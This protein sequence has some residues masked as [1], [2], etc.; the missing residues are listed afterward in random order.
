MKKLIMVALMLMNHLASADVKENSNLVDVIGRNLRIAIE[1]VK[2]P[3]QSP[4]GHTV[5][6]S[7]CSVEFKNCKAI[8]LQNGYSLEKIADQR[9]IEQIELA[10][11]A[12][13]DLLIL[14]A[15]VYTVGSVVGLLAA[16]SYGGNAIAP[17]MLAGGAV[18]TTGVL[19][20]AS[21]VTDAFNPFEQYEQVKV[22]NEEIIGDRKDLHTDDTEV[23]KFAKRLELLLNKI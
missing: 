20:T 21:I 2:N 8:G 5:K 15:S 23:L 19:A 1:V 12:G 11:S 17:A 10:A 3:T 4:N 16:F 9:T 7:L 22:L 14:T 6:F 13:A 18:T